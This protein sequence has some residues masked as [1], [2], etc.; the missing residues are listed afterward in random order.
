MDASVLT[1][2]AMRRV[3]FSCAPPTMLPDP[4]INESCRHPA[5][6]YQVGTLLKIPAL[7]F[8]S[9]W[10]LYWWCRVFFFPFFCSVIQLWIGRSLSATVGCFCF[11]TLNHVSRMREFVHWGKSAGNDPLTNERSF[12]NASTPVWTLILRRVTPEKKRE[13]VARLHRI[14]HWRKATLNMSE[15]QRRRMWESVFKLRRFL[16]RLY[17]K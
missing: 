6:N 9:P 8:T 17:L 1:T 10:R 12:P 3:R 7:R 5:Q 11:A 2:Q 16:V 13:E 4:L 14:C 15:L